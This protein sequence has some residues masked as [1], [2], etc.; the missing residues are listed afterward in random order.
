MT[1]PA[2]QDRPLPHPPLLTAMDLADHAHIRH[3][4]F[5]RRGGVSTDPLFASLNCGYGSQDAKAHVQENRARVA[6]ALGTAHVLALHQIHSA[7]TVTAITP[8]E[9]ADAPQADAMVTNR[10]DIGLGI[11]TA[12]CCPVLLA[13]AEAGVIGAAHAGWKGALA[14]VIASVIAAMGTLGARPERIRAALGPTIQQANYEVGPEFSD[15]FLAADPDSERF[16][17]PAAREGHWLFD[18]PGFVTGALTR[19]GVVQVHDL[20]VCTYADA[21]GYFSYRR[22]THRGEPDYGRN[23]SVISLAGSSAGKA[24]IQRYGV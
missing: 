19:A 16:F 15:R 21:D 7:K 1:L 5:G 20:A 17:K 6:A 23:I 18:L 14:G 22:T 11:L 13:D 4:F 8:W 9:R 12:D 3:G 10:A 2:A 24:S